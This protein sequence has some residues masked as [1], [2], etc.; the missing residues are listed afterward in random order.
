MAGPGKVRTQLDV[1]AGELAQQL[2]VGLLCAA[3]LVEHLRWFLGWDTAGIDRSV[4]YMTNIWCRISG[5]PS[6]SPRPKLRVV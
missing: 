4:T 5:I 6:M 2:F 1:R 3:T